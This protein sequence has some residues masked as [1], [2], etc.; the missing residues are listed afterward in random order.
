[1]RLTLGGG[2]VDGPSQRALLNWTRSVTSDIRDVTSSRQ[3][4]AACTG[5]TLTLVTVTASHK[6][7]DVNCVHIS[8]CV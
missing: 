6:N 2:R 1:M 3:G 4:A 7:I 8:T 5:A